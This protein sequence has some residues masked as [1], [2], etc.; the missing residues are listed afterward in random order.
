MSKKHH[1]LKKLNK[2]DVE[3]WVRKHALELQVYPVELKRW[4]HQYELITEVEK[5]IE[6]KKLAR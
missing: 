4:I 2:L 1:E 3:D 6:K 5:T